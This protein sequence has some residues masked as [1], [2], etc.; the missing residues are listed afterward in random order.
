MSLSQHEAPQP[1]VWVVWVTVPCAELA[2]TFAD[3]L[4]AEKLAACVAILPPVTS[5]YTWQCTTETAKETLLM[6]KPPRRA[7]PPCKHG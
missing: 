7:T 1:T 3:G 2:K 4:V 5:V 6:I